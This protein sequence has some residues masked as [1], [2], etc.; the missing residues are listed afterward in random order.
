MNFDLRKVGASR[1]MQLNDLEEL[2]LVAYYNAAKEWATRWHDNKIINR[3]L[4]PNDKVLLYNLGLCF[5]QERSIL[6]G[7]NL[8]KFI[9]P[10][11]MDISNSL[12]NWNFLKSADNLLNSTSKD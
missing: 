4:A 3:N 5:F 1:L 6:N 12:T 9:N 10:Y 2:R 8:S 7:Q 11:V